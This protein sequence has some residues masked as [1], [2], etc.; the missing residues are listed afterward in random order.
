MNR[1][2]AEDDDDESQRLFHKMPSTNSSCCWQFS[3][4]EHLAFLHFQKLTA[5]GQSFPDD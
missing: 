4:S 1:R 3:G 2:T 5:V